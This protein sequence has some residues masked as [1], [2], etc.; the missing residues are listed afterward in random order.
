MRE[1]WVEIE[2]GIIAKIYNGNSINERLKEVKYKLCITGLNYIGTKDVSFDGVINYKNG[3]KIPENEPK[4]KIAPKGCV[5]VC[6]EGGSAGRKVGY[7]EEDIC[8]GNKL[9]AITNEYGGFEGKYVYYYT[10]YR[11][12]F[13]LFKNQMNGIIGGVSAKKFSEIP[14]DFAPLPEQRAIV[15]KIEEL[16][17]SLDSGMADLKKAQAQLKIYRQA[18]LSSSF[19]NKKLVEISKVI[20]DLTQGWSPKCL[21]Q[22]SI[23]NEEWAV[24]KTT[25]VQASKFIEYENKIL[26]LSLSPR[27]QHEIK[28]GDILITRAGPR[29]RVGIC[30]LV[31]KTR[32]KLINCDKVYRITLNTKLVMPEYFEYCI[33]SPEI[34]SRIEKMKSGSSD[35]G[36]NLTQTVFLRLQ[37]HLPSI[38]EQHQIVQEIESR[39]SVCDKV[40]ETIVE[41]L[42]KSKAL[43]QSILK[44][45][46]EGKL[47]SKQE[48]A[49]CKS[50]P[51]YEPASVLLKR[52]KAEKATNAKNVTVKKSK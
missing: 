20:N 46:F 13:E 24:I 39:L 49:T 33:N 48:L 31:K 30:C 41:S 3:V 19:S 35:S 12:F 25:A 7:V 18:V 14:I 16:F 28:I 38:Q 22:K 23:D 34:L 36:L 43:R 47:L 11:K 10:M 6:S 27:E 26:P 21:N 45:A 8:F 5:L 2:L 17:S 40:E 15:A 32:P 1:D 9:Y 29:I 52:I 51:D 50:A 44:K 42:E 4:F 37:I